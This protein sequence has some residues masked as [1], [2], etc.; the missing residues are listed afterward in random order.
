MY[1]IV[2][3]RGSVK[4]RGTVEDTLEMMHLK[5]PNNCVLLP[6]NETV[7]GMI[8]KTKDLVAYGIINAKTLRKLVAKWG[9]SGNS[10]LDK[11]WF[12]KKKT[13]LDAVVDK[14][15]K[16]QVTLQEL[17]I[18]PLF[19]LH[20]PRRGYKGVKIPFSLGGALGNHGE[21]INDLLERMI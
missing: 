17:E 18:N 16:N 13:T 5:K 12:A 8:H 2:R 11:E 15:A 1:A 10:E 20:P 21:K 3:V 6:E 7:K 4:T 14:L 9:R 19:R